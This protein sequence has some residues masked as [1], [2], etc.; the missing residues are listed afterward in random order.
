MGLDPQFLQAIL[1]HE[2]VNITLDAY[3]RVELEDVKRAFAKL[4]FL[5]ARS[6]RRRGSTED[7]N[8][9]AELRD[10][11]PAGREQAWQQVIDGL[12]G[13]LVEASYGGVEAY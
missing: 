13:L 6:G 7:R 11:T 5:G 4:D 10:S 2:S 9:L 1:A 3:A 12:E 8:L